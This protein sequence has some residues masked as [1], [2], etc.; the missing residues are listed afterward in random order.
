MLPSE[1]GEVVVVVVGTLLTR[2]GVGLIV[3]LAGGKRKCQQDKGGR[4]EQLL[5][6]WSEARPF[7]CANLNGRA[8]SSPAHG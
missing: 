4:E 6:S 5:F 7:L 1:A 3:T 8:P 2:C